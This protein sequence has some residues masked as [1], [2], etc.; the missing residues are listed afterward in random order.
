MKDALL[1]AN[2][3]LGGERGGERRRPP[4]WAPYVSMILTAIGLA[5]ALGVW[6]PAWKLEDADAAEKI[7]QELVSLIDRNETK[8]ELAHQKLFDAIQHLEQRTFELKG[9]K[10]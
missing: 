2:E 8:H 10:P 3:S 9:A 7:H 1:E 4:W 6:K 5:F